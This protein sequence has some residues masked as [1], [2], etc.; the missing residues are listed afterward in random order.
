MTQSTICSMFWNHLMIDGTGRV[1]PCCRFADKVNHSLNDNTLSEIFYNE[2][3]ENLRHQSKNG[4]TITGCQRCYEEE[5]NNKLSLR[6]RLNNHNVIGLDSIDMDNPKIQYLELSLSNACNLMCR[7]CDS[8]YSY[9]LFN[10]EV[11]Y[12]GKPF[13]KTE[14]TK[15]NIDS[16]YPLLKNC[17]FIKF[18]GGEPLIIPDHWNIIDYIISNGYSKNITLNYSTNCTVYPKKKIT[19]AWKEFKNIELAVSLDS[20][21][22]TE[23]EYQR[24]LSVQE[25]IIKNILAYT[26]LPSVKLIARP[27]V[28]IY[29]AYTLPETLTWLHNNNIAFNPTHCSY[30]AH[31]SVT[32]LPRKQKD[33]IGKK[34]KDFKYQSNQ[35]KENCKYIIQFMNSVDESHLFDVFLK[36]TSFLDKER[37]QNFFESYP[38]LQLRHSI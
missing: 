28:T 35:I 16:I 1:K 9:K 8:R 24:H 6:T 19:D 34:Y 31:L 30:P 21:D 14:H 7:M 12:N 36:Y 13:S 15:A 3:F 5:N 29:N 10:E 25:D 22:K 32:T 18:T 26:K 27:T 33:I 17:K 4:N 2:Y 11:K 38:Y 37:N 20:I 23:N